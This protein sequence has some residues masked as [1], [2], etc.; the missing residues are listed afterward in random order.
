K[1]SRM[2]LIIMIF[3]GLGGI[4]FGYDIGIIADALLFLKPDLSLTAQQSSWLIAAVLWGIAAA[5]L[6]SGSFADRYGRRFSLSMSAAVF[7][8]GTIIVVLSNS[9]IT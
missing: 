5:T 2:T 6:F 9:F 1:I 3:A 4:L 8:T 7:I